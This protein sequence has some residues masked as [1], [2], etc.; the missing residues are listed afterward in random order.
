MAQEEAGAQ[1]EGQR[2][3]SSS[4]ASPK[5]SARSTTSSSSGSYASATTANTVEVWD[6]EGYPAR[7][8]DR[9]GKPYCAGARAADRSMVTGENVVDQRCGQFA[10]LVC[11]A[12]FCGDQLGMAV[13][14][15]HD[16]IWLAKC[17]GMALDST[18]WTCVLV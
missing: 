5:G 14:G 15:A 2:S 18:A 7:C 16:I 17:T 8:M 1:G 11:S 13:Q 10:S 4:R 6:S 3:D 9:T 12:K